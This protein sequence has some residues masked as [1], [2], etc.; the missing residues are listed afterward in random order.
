MTEVNDY[1]NCMTALYAA[2][3]KLDEKLRDRA[4]KHECLVLAAEIALQAKRV[5]DYLKERG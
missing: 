4:P 1:A 2:Y 3:K 5:G